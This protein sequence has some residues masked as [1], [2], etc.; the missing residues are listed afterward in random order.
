M[1]HECA[2]GKCVRWVATRTVTKSGVER[3]CSWWLCESRRDISSTGRDDDSLSERE[4]RRL[5]DLY[6]KPAAHRS[7]SH[8]HAE[9]PYLSLS[10]NYQS[11]SLATSDRARERVRSTSFGLN[12]H[13]Q[14]PVGP[15]SKKLIYCYQESVPAH[16]SWR[17]VLY[18][19][20]ARG[21]LFNAGLTRNSIDTLTVPADIDWEAT[22]EL[23]REIDINRELKTSHIF[24]L[25]GNMSIYAT[26]ARTIRERSSRHF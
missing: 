8:T 23:H 20:S 4:V 17:A 1:T 6:M 7:T 14:A 11:R 16:D 15:L 22:G 24:S 26:G 25:G 13:R 3:V 2:Y 12:S 19:I 18:R 21:D 10:M 9:W 5:R